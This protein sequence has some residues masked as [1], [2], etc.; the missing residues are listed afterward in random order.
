MVSHV[1]L[2]QA[3]QFNVLCRKITNR[4]LAENNLCASLVKS[5]HLVED[6]LPLGI[7][8]G[9]VF[10]HLLNTDFSVVLLTL[11]LELDVQANDLG[12]LERLGLLLET[13]VG[14]GLL[15]CDTVDEQGIL[16]GTTSDLLDTDESVVEVV[17]VEGEDSVDNHCRA[18]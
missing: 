3:S 14:E 15:E 9:L 16:Q 1:L 10:R 12:V 17:L 18:C 13:G 4:Q 11:E 6:N 8:D 2:I 5:L 7:D